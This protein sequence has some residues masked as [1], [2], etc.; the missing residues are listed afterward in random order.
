MKATLPLLSILALPL[1]AT[2]VFTIPQGYTKITIPAASG[3]TPSLTAISTNLYND[4][5]FSGTVTINADFNADPDSDLTTT[6]TSQ[7]LTVSG[8]SFT[9]GEF[10]TDPYLAYLINASGAEE[11]F[12]ITDHTATTLT[13]DGAF[14]LLADSR[15]TTSSTLKIRKANTVGSI[16]GTTDTPFSS[17]DRAYIWTGSNWQ[18][19]IAASGNWF[20]IG[21]PGGLATD[22][23]IFP[24]E[25][26]FIQRTETTD[27]VLTFFGEIPSTPQTTTVA[28]LSSA[29][30][31]T[32]FPSGDATSAQGI[33]GHRLADLDIDEI[34]GW[35]STDRAFHWNGSEWQTL[36]SAGSSWFFIG[37]ALNGT[38][39]NDLIVEANS[40]LFLSRSSAGTASASTLTLE[41]PYPIILSE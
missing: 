7:T 10:T 26:I 34:P 37:G 25:G 27:A 15:F 8:A 38:S 40:A 13:L 41:L 12:L 6:D 18:T 23:V 35:N 14:D 31:S 9:T 16:L 3:G 36:I 39:A 11:A 19:L 32:R 29:F 2:T 24:E 4:T 17:N 33:V 30:I 1:F 20:F 28:G 5:E 21:G 22:A